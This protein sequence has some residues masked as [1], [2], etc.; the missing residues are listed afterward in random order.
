MMMLRVMMPQCKRGCA[1]P[2]AAGDRGRRSH[3]GG[4]PATLRDVFVA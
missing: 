3:E 2:A 1:P 4:M